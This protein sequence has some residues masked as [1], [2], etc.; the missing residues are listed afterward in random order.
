MI[1]SIHIK[2]SQEIRIPPSRAIQSSWM[3]VLFASRFIQMTL[4]TNNVTTAAGIE[5]SN[6]LNS[7]ISLFIF[8]IIVLLYLILVLEEVPSIS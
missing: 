1:I 5:R 6:S 7:L 8:S 4:T 2:D 3:R